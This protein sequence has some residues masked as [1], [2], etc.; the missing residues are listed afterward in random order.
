MKLFTA[1]QIAEPF[2]L[3]KSCISVEL[4]STSWVSKFGKRHRRLLLNFETQLNDKHWPV[5][6]I[7][8]RYIS[9]LS[10]EIEH[11]SP[12]RH[13]E[14]QHRLEQRSS[15]VPS[16]IRCWYPQPWIPEKKYNS[17]LLHIQGNTN[18]QPYIEDTSCQKG[19]HS[20]I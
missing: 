9:C 13:R 12:T 1:T 17:N 16:P 18:A 20:F 4:V 6:T 14:Y 5:L 3:H 8:L 2:P 10:V 19:N 15:R 7:L 11:Q